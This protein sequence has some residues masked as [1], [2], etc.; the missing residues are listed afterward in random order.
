MSDGRCKTCKHWGNT[1]SGSDS[2]TFKVQCVSPHFATGETA[3]R[4]GAVAVA[5]KE[6][7]VFGQQVGARGIWTGPDFGCIHWEQA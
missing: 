7:V 6:G 1:I 3:D 5:C 4:A 2:A